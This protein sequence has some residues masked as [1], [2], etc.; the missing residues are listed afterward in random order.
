MSEIFQEEDS[1][2]G[3]LVFRPNASFLSSLSR[4]MVGLG[5][6][7]LI[8]YNRPAPLSETARRNILITSH[9]GLARSSSSSPSHSEKI[10]IRPGHDIEHCEEFQ[11]KVSDL[12]TIEEERIFAISPTPIRKKVRILATTLTGKRH[13]I[14]ART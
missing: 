11:K 5:P 12:I 9:A 2:S 1:G 7:V 6:A 3:K 8:L 14:L 10:E 4:E 13:A